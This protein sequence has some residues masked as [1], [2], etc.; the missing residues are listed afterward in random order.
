VQAVVVPFHVRAAL[1]LVG[2]QVLA[3]LLLTPSAP[4]CRGDALE[5][6][7]SEVRSAMRL[8]RSQMGS[9]DFSF[10]APLCTSMMR[11]CSLVAMSLASLPCILGTET[12]KMVSALRARRDLS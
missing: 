8:A 2:D 11:A 1:D 5:R 10:A 9:F 6:V 12:S 3:D 7:Q 4:L